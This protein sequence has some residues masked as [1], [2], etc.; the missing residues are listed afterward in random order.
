MLRSIFFCLMIALCLPVNAKDYN[1]YL[2]TGPG[3]QTDIIARKIQQLYHE[4]TGNRLILN[5]APGGDQIV[6]ATRFLADKNISLIYGGTSMHFYNYVKHKSLP[7]TD[8]DFRHVSWVGDIP[9][10]YVVSADSNIK[11]IQDFK[12]ILATSTKPFIGVYDSVTQ[13]NVLSLQNHYD[14]RIEPIMFKD[15]MQLQ[16]AIMGRHIEVGLMSRTDNLTAMIDQGHIRVIGQTSNQSINL[17]MANVPAVGQVL[18]IPQFTAGGMISATFRI[19]S[20]VDMLIK[21]VETLIQT[22]E[23]KNFLR[24]MNIVPNNIPSQNLHQFVLHRRSIIS[25]LFIA[26]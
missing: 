17:A 16:V 24:S 6:T 25:N 5:Y 12:K 19:D 13:A 11:N 4:K 26:Q 18:D 9:Q 10:Y 2:I 15:P 7:Y 22:D 1:F 20:E 3:S 23:M 21:D 14:T 8:K